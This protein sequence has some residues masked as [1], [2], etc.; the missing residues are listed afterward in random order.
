VRISAPETGLYWRE[1]LPTISE[2]DKRE[3]RE[4]TTI[5]LK[6]SGFSPAIRNNCIVV[7]GMGACARPQPGTTRNE[8]I[9]KID[10]VARISEGDVAVWVGV[11]SNFYNETVGYGN[12]GLRF[13]ETA[14]FRNGTPVVLG[15]VT[16]QL[17]EA[18]DNAYGATLEKSG[19]RRA[20][21]GGHERG[22]ALRAQFAKDLRIDHSATLDV[23]LI[24]KEHP[25]LAI[26]FTAAIEGEGEIG[27]VLRAIAKTIVVNGSLVGERVFADVV[28]DR[29]ALSLYVTRPYM[30]TGLLTVHFGAPHSA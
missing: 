7:G 24:L 1:E 13:S 30:E 9:A 17:T 4:G 27:E 22:F 21:L 26:D 5:I 10:P 29:D 2:I 23:C 3:G 8:L 20:S 16:F 18:S 28:A 6:G 12:I 19:D 14:I 11:G 25:T 15:H